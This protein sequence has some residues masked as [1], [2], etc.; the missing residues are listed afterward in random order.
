[1]GGNEVIRLH[2]NRNLHGQAGSREV[3]G[4]HV[5]PRGLRKV[6]MTR[7][8][9]LVAD[10]SNAIANDLDSLFRPEGYRVVY[11]PNG[12]IALA[13]VRGARPDVIIADVMLRVFTGIEFVRELRRNP[14]LGQIPVILWSA[15]SR[16]HG[17][18]SRLR[19]FYRLEEVR[20]SRR[21]ARA[22]LEPDCP[23]QDSSTSLKTAK[24]MDRAVKQLTDKE[25][26][27]GNSSLGS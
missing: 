9:I 11:A 25:T 8:T 2:H 21:A 17:L 18:C 19:T 24:T 10:D 13:I 5:A 14:D 22:R 23:A 20:Q 27:D 12:S 4:P 1:M 3:A 7:R 6:W 16:H 15:V 26:H